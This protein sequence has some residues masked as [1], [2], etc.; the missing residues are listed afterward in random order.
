V[1]INETTIYKAMAEGELPSP[2]EWGGSTY[3]CI[4][5][6]GVGVAYRPFANEYVFRDPKTWTT[7]RMLKRF[8]SLPVL[9]SHPS[10]G[11]LDS[12]YFGSNCI[13]ITCYAYICPVEKCPWVVCR[14]IDKGAA[15]LIATGHCCS[16][17]G[18]VTNPET[19]GETVIDGTRLLV[20]S[21]PAQIDHLAV[22][23]MGR[24][25]DQPENRGVWKRDDPPGVLVTE[26]TANTQTADSTRAG[27]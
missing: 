3:V 23:W 2:Y 15:D 7:P 21:E 17:P 27:A 9:W 14:I 1:N 18:V 6:T 25:L 11:M 12:T 10:T 4:R 20:E 16:S 24:D 26:E 8:E 5:A 19:C 22:V 13:G